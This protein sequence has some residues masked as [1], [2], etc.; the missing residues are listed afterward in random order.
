MSIA[1]P[2]PHLVLDG[3]L[4]DDEYER[5]LDHVRNSNEF[6]PAQVDLPDGAVR[7]IDDTIR[8]ARVA[9][10]D[11][12]IDELFAARLRSILPHARRELDV[13]HFRLGRIEWQLTAHGQGDFFG[14]HTD[15]GTAWQPS[16]ARRVSF[17][18]Y[19]HER[20]RTFEGGELRLY[21]RTIDSSGVVDRCESFQEVQPTGNS[22]V[23]FPSDAFHEVRPIETPGDPAAPGAT[24]YALTGWFHDA[25]HRLADPPVDRE[26]LAALVERYAPTYTD[27]GF[28]KV[29]TPAPVHRALAAL[30]AER[31]DA[32]FGERPDEFHLPTGTPDFIDIDD[33]KAQFSLALQQVHEEWAGCELEPTAVYGLRVYRRGQTLVPHTDILE[34][35]VISSI[36]HIGH[37]TDEPWPLW[38][39]DIHGVEHDIVLEPGEML[40]YES[41][42]CRHGRV[43]PLLGDSYCSLFVHYRPIDWHVDQ[44]YLVERAIAAG[45]RELIPDGWLP[46]GGTTAPVES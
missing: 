35:H 45:D 24:R 42:R 46:S 32:R 14:L 40:L 1:Q 3:F 25:D 34:T 21:D 26:T 41:A 16:S 33:A 36:V 39:E 18:F 17:V 22:I 10:A 28:A 38:F 37:D 43:V 12:V 5:L 8:R 11:E 23:L 19:F 31:F 20:P 9:T 29:P 13:A 7:R 15:L 27:S 4:S 6:S 2:V 44:R 30:Y